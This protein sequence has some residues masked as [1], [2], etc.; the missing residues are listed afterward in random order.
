MKSRTSKNITALHQSATLLCSATLLVVLGGCGKAPTPQAD[1]QG[2]TSVA[3]Q[4]AATAGSTA[5]DKVMPPSFLDEAPSGPVSD[6]IILSGGTLLGETE[7]FDAIVI[8]TRGQVVGAGKR[9]DVPV[10]ADSIGIDTSGRFIEINGDAA[11]PQSQ[12]AN[13]IVYED[14][15]TQVADAAIHGAF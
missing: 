1:G 11:L 2:T 7:V 9:G 12:R 3:E 10:P 15:P 6:T 14:H 13:V 8:V 4:N 5:A